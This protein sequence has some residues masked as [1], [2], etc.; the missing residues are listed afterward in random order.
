MAEKTQEADSGLDVAKLIVAGFIVLVGVVGFYI[1]SEQ[2][3]LYRVLGL[4]VL[5]A[6]GAGIGL[7]TA[8]GKSLA[9]FMQG[10]RT[11]VRK[12]VWPTR[13]ETMQT[14]LLIFVAVILVGLFLW[15]LDTFL[16]WFM[17]MVIS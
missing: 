7:T 17:R 15:L 13:V 8:R 6:I 1:Y 10:A 14:T 3:L 5:V 12:M 11:E 2:P 9:I 4:L 16:A